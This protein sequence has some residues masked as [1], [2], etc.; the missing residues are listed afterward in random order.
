MTS[1]AYSTAYFFR[2]LNFSFYYDFKYLAIFSFY[3]WIFYNYANF[4]QL[5]FAYLLSSA[6]YSSASIASFKSYFLSYCFLLCG[7]MGVRFLKLA[8]DS[9]EPANCLGPP[10][11][12]FVSSVLNCSAF[13][14]SGDY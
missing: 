5:S 13:L 14:P 12:R 3:S 1:A 10:D 4:S 11:Q 7:L 8:K 2:K 6:F 9:I